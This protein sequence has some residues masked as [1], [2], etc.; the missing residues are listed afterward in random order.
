MAF[1]GCK[2]FDWLE[3]HGDQVLALEPTPPIR[4]PYIMLA[5]ARI[6]EADKR[7]LATPC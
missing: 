6:V 4:H 5:K 7:E 2:F 1:G 3:Q